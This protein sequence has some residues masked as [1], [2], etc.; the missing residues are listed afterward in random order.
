MSKALRQRVQWRGFCTAAL[1]WQCVRCRAG[2]A[3][4]CLLMFCCHRCCLST[5]AAEECAVS[6]PCVEGGRPS[7]R[8]LS[9]C[10][11]LCRYPCRK[12]EDGFNRITSA[13]T[14]MKSRQQV[15]LGVLYGRGQLSWRARFFFASLLRLSL[16]PHALSSAPGRSSLT[17]HDKMLQ[18]RSFCTLSRGSTL[19]FDANE[20]LAS[21]SSLPLC[22]CH[23]SERTGVRV[24]QRRDA[25]QQRARGGAR[26]RDPAFGWLPEPQL[27]FPLMYVLIFCGGGA[28]PTRLTSDMRKKSFLCPAHDGAAGSAGAAS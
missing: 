17:A 4:R 21:I 27:L 5:A 15:A 7:T 10:G 20:L 23:R 12:A 13:N 18:M 16:F 3:G 28:D 8:P 26:P 14:D 19:R 24:H 11:G 9:L 22:H 1:L 6:C 2:N 25:V